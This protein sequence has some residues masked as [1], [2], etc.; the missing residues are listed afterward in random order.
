MSTTAKKYNGAGNV[1]KN[2]KIKATLEVVKDI[3]TE[4]TLYGLETYEKYPTTLEDHFGGSQRATVLA[5]AAGGATALATAQ[6]RPVSLA[7]TCP[8]TCTK[9]H[10][11]DS[12]SSDTTCRIS[13]VPQTSV[14]QGD[15]GS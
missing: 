12:D 2:N 3:A 1:G 8:C 4:S 9:K 14:L 13:A 10:T 6:Q 5:V 11:A 15:E 7:G